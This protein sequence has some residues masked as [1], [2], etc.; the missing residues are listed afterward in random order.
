MN[1]I[2][3][4]S[5]FKKESILIYFNYK[6]SVIIDADASERIMRAWLQQINNQEQKRLIACYTQKLTLTEQQYDIHD[7]EMLAIIKALEQW[8]TYLQEAKYQIII[9]SDHK[10]L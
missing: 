9:K 6:K 2:V 8:R 3:K 10:N 4:L 5:K 1:F 7:R